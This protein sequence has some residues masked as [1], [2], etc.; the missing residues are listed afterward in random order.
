M[1]IPPDR[2]DHLRKMV[3]DIRAKMWERTWS[4]EEY[5]QRN[6]YLMTSLPAVLAACDDLLDV[7]STGG[8]S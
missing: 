8:K 2:I 3:A 7:V 1:N 5:R 6:Y 4:Q